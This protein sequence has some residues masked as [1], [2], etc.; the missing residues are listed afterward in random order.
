MPDIKILVVDDEPDLNDLVVQ[1]LDMYGYQTISA[2]TGAD[3]LRMAESEN[4]DLILLDMTLPDAR[5]EEIFMRLKQNDATRDI[6]IFIVSAGTSDFLAQFIN[7]RGITQEDVFR[8]PLDFKS[9][10]ARM[11]SI[12][13]E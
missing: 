11:A 7:S 9:R 5:G 2:F 6:Q 12:F 10:L 1:R 3:A 4:P 13:T 8:K